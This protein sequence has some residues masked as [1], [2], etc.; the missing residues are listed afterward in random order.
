MFGERVPGRSY[1]VRRAAYA[2]IFG[3]DGRVATVK[4]RRGHFL[5]GGG[6]ERGE[7]DES[8]LVR[9]VREECAREIALA[10][11]VGEAVQWFRASRGFFEGHHVFF[12]GSFAGEPSGRGEHELICLDPARGDGALP[13]E[14]LRW[15]IGLPRD[16]P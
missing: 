14:S 15:A 7:S 3:D 5:P 8:G 12:A 2:V 13:R 6:I 4:T 10:R 9:E 11:C 1:T 16:K